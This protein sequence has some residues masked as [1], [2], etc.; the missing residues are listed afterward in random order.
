V[1][2]LQIHDLPIKKLKFERISGSMF[3]V[4]VNAFTVKNE[5]YLAPIGCG[6]LLSIAKSQFLKVF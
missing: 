1:A 5:Q 4:R 6:F 3:Y 2:P